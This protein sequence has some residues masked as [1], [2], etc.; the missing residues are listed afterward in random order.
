MLLVGNTR[1]DFVKLNVQC[2]FLLHYSSQWLL[3]LSFLSSWSDSGGILAC[4]P[5]QTFKI[6]FKVFKLLHFDLQKYLNRTSCSEK[7]ANHTQNFQ[8]LLF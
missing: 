1:K 8:D 2:N 7:E 4:V 6:T 3:C 5:A